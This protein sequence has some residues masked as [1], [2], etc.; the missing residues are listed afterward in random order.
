[1]GEVKRLTDYIVFSKAGGFW[2]GCGF[3]GFV[4]LLRDFFLIAPY[5]YY[6]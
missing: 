2:I 3:G 4:V 6:K 1:M 5:L